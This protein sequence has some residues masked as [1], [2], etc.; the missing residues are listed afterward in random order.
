MEPRTIDIDGE[1]DLVIRVPAGDA[2]IGVTDGTT[3]TV[4]ITGERSPDDLTIEASASAGGGTRLVVA[5][6]KESA[7]GWFRGS[8]LRV[9][10]EVP[11]R[12]AVEAV[13][14]SAD[15]VVDGEVRDLAFRS[16]SGDLRA[17]SISGAVVVKT[18]SGD[19]RAERVGGDVVATTASGDITVGSIEGSLTARTAS[20]DLQI[21][22]LDGKGQASS[23]SGDLRLR[24]ADSDLQ[25]RSVSGD[26]E[27]G[28]RPGRRIWFDLSSTSG[29]AVS[30]LEPSGGGDEA[31]PAAEIRATSVSGDI[32]IRR[33][34]GHTVAR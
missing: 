33:A 34:D 12:T 32:R 19:V 29:D 22:R 25:L 17:A 8:E 5:H 26:I 30:D 28:V 27:V 21:D 14:D 9:D 18:A 24:I 20:G 3:A 2:R 11:T 10:I 6:R 4:S 16:G 1:L 31:G 15:L 23:A 7:F 13:T